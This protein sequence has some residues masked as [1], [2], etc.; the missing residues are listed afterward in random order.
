MIGLPD[1]RRARLLHA[2]AGVLSSVDSSFVL[3]PEGFAQFR[4]KDL[5]G[6]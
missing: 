4:F 2:R 1:L 6:A 5:T 3:R